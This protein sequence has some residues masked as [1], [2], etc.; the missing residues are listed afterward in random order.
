[1]TETPGDNNLPD[2]SEAY[3]DS[4]WT[5]ETGL[6]WECTWVEGLGW[7]WKSLGAADNE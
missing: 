3:A 1:M 2:A 5:D 6:V 7:A 4:L